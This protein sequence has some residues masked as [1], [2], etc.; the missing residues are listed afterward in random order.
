MEETQRII[1]DAIAEVE[2]WPPEPAATK[3]NGKERAVVPI[4]KQEFLERFGQPPDYLIAGLM[5]KGFIYALTGQTG[6]AK[7]AIALLLAR[8]VCSTNQATLGG[9]RI[10]NGRVIYFVGENPADVAFRIKGYDLTRSD[11]PNADMISFIPGKFDIAAIVTII[12]D[13]IRHNGPVAMIIVD[14]SAAYFPGNDEINNTQIGDYARLLRRLTTLSS[15]PCVLVLCHPIKHAQEQNQLLPRGGGAYL[16]EM[17]ANLTLWKTGDETVELSW[18]KLR[19]PNFEPLT[20]KLVPIKSP[21]LV[22]VDGN[23]V[24]T[25]DAELISSGEEEKIATESRKAQDQ[26]LVAMLKLPATDDHSG[27]SL[28]KWAEHVGWVSERGAPKK[29]QVER[30]IKEKLAKAKPKALVT[31]DRD[32]WKLTE[33]GVKEAGRITSRVELEAEAASQSAMEFR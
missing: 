29:K 11:D 30:I 31:L 23:P 32:K 33:A 21:R 16:A 26:V 25:V 17:D 18:T 2:S 15:R 3:A 19:G 7:T 20:F 22:D 27:G 28:A 10:K 13:D 12:E 24:T 5:Q 1:S 14:T 9:R 8:L 4:S 6:H